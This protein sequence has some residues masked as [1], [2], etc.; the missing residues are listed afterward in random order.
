MRG[1]TCDHDEIF[2]WAQRH[3]AVPAEVVPRK[4]DGEPSLLYFLFGRERAGTPEIRPISWEDFFARF[5]LMELLIVYDD[6]PYF[7]LLQPHH[8]SFA[9]RNPDPF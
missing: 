9:R 3:S 1:P 4:F 2:L 6:S 5:D 7:E 8:V